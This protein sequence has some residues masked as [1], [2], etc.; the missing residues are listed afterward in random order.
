VAL[1]VPG[2]ESVP[3]YREMLQ[4]LFA[5]DIEFVPPGFVL[6]ND[7]PE[8]SFLKDERLWMTNLF[9]AA[10]VGARSGVGI[11]NRANSGVVVVV[12]HINNSGGTPV[13]ISQ[14]ASPALPPNY[15][16]TGAAQVRDSRVTNMMA[17]TLARNTIAGQGRAERWILAANTP[18]LFTIPIVIGPDASLTIEGN[19]DNV[20]V[21]VALAGYEH[22]LRAEEL[23]P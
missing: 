12:T 22:S 21:Q 14:P 4:R 10:V 18:Y 20:A 17:Q 16:V 5:E 8:W 9:V 2:F 7:R 3:R 1:G 19:A 13:F 6:D 23:V 15:V 11:G